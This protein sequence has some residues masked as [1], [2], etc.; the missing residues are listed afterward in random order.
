MVSFEE[1]SEY[2]KKSGLV[3]VETSAKESINVSKAFTIVAEKILD[4]IIKKRIN[5]RE[6][7]GIKIGDELRREIEV[8]QS[9]RVDV[10]DS[11]GCCS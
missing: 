9:K 11:T 5:P 2:A 6:E 3:Y 4:G 8:T 1:A 10:D 7:Q